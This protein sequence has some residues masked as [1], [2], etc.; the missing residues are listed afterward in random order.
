M[1]N[2]LSS[3]GG[4]KPDKLFGVKLNS[5]DLG[6]PLTV[7]IGCVKTNQ[8]IFW[9]DGFRA[10]QQSKKSSGGGGKGGGKGDGQ[11]LYSADLVAGLCAGPVIG[12]GD[13]WTGQSW[14]GS[15]QAN[16]SYTI[17]SPSY[18]YTPTNATCAD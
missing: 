7:V 11:Y 9:I 12:I 5:S 1:G 6:K 16:E 4:N 15:P 3:G 10:Q 17:A 13:V 14:L 18:T 8:L 2:I